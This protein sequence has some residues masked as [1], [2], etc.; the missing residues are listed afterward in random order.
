ML[1]VLSSNAN[2]IF[3]ILVLIS[4][5]GILDIKDIVWP[6]QAL[7]PPEGI[8]EKRFIKASFL[9]EDPYVMLSPPST[10]GTSNKGKEKITTANILQGR[11]LVAWL[12]I[13]L[14][15]IPWQK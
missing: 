12:T 10:C 8:P 9:E 15:W 14:R 5:G 3:S 2:Y 7:K 6:G 1:K 13:L 11:S 4:V